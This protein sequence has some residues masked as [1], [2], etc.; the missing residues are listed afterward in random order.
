MQPSNN[1]EEGITKMLRTVAQAEAT[2][3]LQAVPKR[4][5]QWLLE[6]VQE[7]EPARASWW[8]KAFAI[9]VA[10]HG[11]RQSLQIGSVGLLGGALLGG[12][13]VHW[14]NRKPSHYPKPVPPWVDAIAQYQSLYVRETVGE[15]AQSTD[16]AQAVIQAFVQATGVPNF[17]IPDL[18]GQGFSFQRAQRLS[19]NRLPLLQL[20]Y[21]PVIGLPLALCAMPAKLLGLEPTA[22][23]ITSSEVMAHGMSNVYWQRNDLAWVA[24]ANWPLEQLRALSLH[25]QK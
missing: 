1:D 17:K 18:S 10:S 21:L 16:Q 13:A 3:P 22:T 15:I 24:V 9:T 4:L 7:K 5:E 11:R 6:R 25:L 19:F 12:A 14:L 2:R 23:A 20:V 8:N